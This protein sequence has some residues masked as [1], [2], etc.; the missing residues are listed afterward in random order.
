MI[1]D[2]ETDSNFYR[3]SRNGSNITIR[4]EKLNT[5]KTIPDIPSINLEN[6]FFSKASFRNSRRDQEL[7]DKDLSSGDKINYIAK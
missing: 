1:D 7:F 2:D 6:P 5:D 4:Q 3:D